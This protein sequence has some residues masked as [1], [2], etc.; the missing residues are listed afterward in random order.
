VTTSPAFSWRFL[1]PRYW[2]TWLGLGAMWLLA[3]LP[4]PIQTCAGHALGRLMGRLG[5]GRRRVAAVNLALCLPALSAAEREHLLWRHLESVGMGVVET[6]ISWWTPARRL[7][8]VQV[9]GLEHLQAALQ[10]HHGAILLIGHFTCMELIAR[11]LAPYAPLHVT[12]RQSKNALYEYMLHRAHRH[13]APPP[14]H[15]T[16]LRAMFRALKRNELLWYAPDQN[17]AG[18]H[19]AFV[20]FFGIPA[21]T[22]TATTRIARTSGAPVI[23]IM[24]QRLPSG[25][26]YRVA[27]QP[28]L[29]DFPGVD[30]VR[31]AARIL[32]LIEVQARQFP[33]QYLWVHRRFKTRP[34]GERPLY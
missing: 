27:L 11:F 21:S 1:T 19:S 20:P 3:Q 6:A 12:Y 34:A 7:P 13:H 9:E 14:V 28:A 32:H 15:H 30:E 23:P 5:Q 22:I 10:R 4:Y 2:P 33:E 25:A 24:A 29:E 18:K 8:P 17:Y 26:G 31:D 16:D